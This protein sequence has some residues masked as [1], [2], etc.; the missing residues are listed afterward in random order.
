MTSKTLSIG[1]L[2][3]GYERYGTLR[4][5]NPAQFFELFQKN[6]ETN[7]PFDDLVDNLTEE[8][9]NRKVNNYLNKTN[10]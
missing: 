8:R 7:I 2:S 10:A 3:L 4:T 9:F 1:E 6:L 5:L